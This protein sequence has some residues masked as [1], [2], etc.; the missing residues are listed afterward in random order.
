MMHTPSGAATALCIRFLHRHP[1][2][3]EHLPASVL[4]DLAAYAVVTSGE[5]NFG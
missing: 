2:E 3:L 5:L 1:L 4:A